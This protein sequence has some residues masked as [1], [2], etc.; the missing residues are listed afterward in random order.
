M[1]EAISKH[2]KIERML[3]VLAFR[4]WFPRIPLSRLESELHKNQLTDIFVK[5]PVF[6]TALPR[7]GT[8]LLLELCAGLNEFASHR[9]SDMPFLMTPLIWN[10]FSENYRSSGA[11]NERVH[12]DG[13]LVNVDS[14]E[15]F[16]EVI[17][18]EFWPSYYRKER[19]I[20]WTEQS[21]P[22]FE[23]FFLEHMRKIIL[24]RGNDDKKA[25]YLS[26]NNL[27]I[28][29]TGY[30]ASAFPD[31][32]ILILFRSPLQHA[33][34][35][36]KQHRNFLRIHKDDNFAR[37]YMEDTGHYDF[38]ENLR[39]VDFDGW[40]SKE[41]ES[42]PNTLA[43]WLLYW[44]NTY[45]YLLKSRNDQVRFFSFDSLCAD[46][47]SG[48]DRLGGILEVENMGQWMKNTNRIINPRPHPVDC[49]GI[50]ASILDRVEDL[51]LDLQNAENR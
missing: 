25:R 10:R 2:T 6:I 44:T 8:T 37:K 48:L 21:Y 1:K 24:L 40:L 36:L 19:V 31:S 50:A 4:S 9:Y 39:P 32:T 33:A 51:Y 12:G 41:G 5:K 43:F 3:H 26:K 49:D 23:E 20:P 42:D 35:L 38:G 14:P 45:R 29:R 15:S 47:K 46:P 13:I 18:K 34:S 27:N 28:A 17:W 11:L 16:E 30:L 22:E 7:A